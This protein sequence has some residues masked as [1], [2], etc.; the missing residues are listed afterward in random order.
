[1]AYLQWTPNLSVGNK[2]L[3]GHHETM[4]DM[5]NFAFEAVGKSDSDEVGS[6]LDKLLDYTRYH[7]SEEE[8]VME[9]AGFPDL[10]EHR[11]IHAELTRQVTDMQQRFIADSAAVPALEIFTFLS[12]WLI[13]HIM[14]KDQRFRPYIEAASWLKNE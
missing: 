7:F 2:T 1:M 3:D 5:I 12:Q 9:A 11:K 4:I 8:K 14:A 10:E 6:T 13:R